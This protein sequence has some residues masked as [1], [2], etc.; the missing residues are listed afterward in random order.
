MRNALLIVAGLFLLIWTIGFFGYGAGGL[1]VHVLL[2]LAALTVVVRIA[3][4]KTDETID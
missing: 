2:L 3:S 1:M 4:D